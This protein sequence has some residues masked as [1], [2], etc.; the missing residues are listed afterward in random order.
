M[1]RRQLFVLV[2]EANCISSLH[3]H[4]S[5]LATDNPQNICEGVTIY[6][7]KY[8]VSWCLPHRCSVILYLQ[9]HSCYCMFFDTSRCD[10]ITDVQWWKILVIMW[11]GKLPLWLSCTISK[12]YSTQPQLVWYYRV[13]TLCLKQPICF[14]W[15]VYEWVPPRR[16]AIQW[17]KHDDETEIYICDGTTIDFHLKLQ[18][19]DFYYESKQIC[20]HGSLLQQMCKGIHVATCSS[21]IQAFT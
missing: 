7:Y 9:K 8:D 17:F 4:Q 13:T 1:L 16:L 18:Q 12:L 3:E 19:I 20:S 6:T 10:S 21:S 11:L 15:C 14:I 2:L 5:Y